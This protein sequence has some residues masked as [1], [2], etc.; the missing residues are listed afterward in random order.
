MEL[1]D[2]TRL[3]GQGA[4]GIHLCLFFQCCDYKGK[5]ACLDFYLGTR[6]Q[7]QIPM[8]AQ[9][10][11]YLPSPSPHHTT[12]FKMNMQWRSISEWETDKINVFRTE[13]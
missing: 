7:S 5:P 1:P 8:F 2:E 9:Q 12:H 11:F 10:A 13:T 6:D 4:P 3:A